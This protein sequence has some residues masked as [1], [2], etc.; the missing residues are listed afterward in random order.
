VLRV[1]HPLALACCVVTVLLIGML[2]AEVA[3]VGGPV[4][5]TAGALM[6]VG[7]WMVGSRAAIAFGAAHVGI[8]VLFVALVNLMSW[9]PRDA[10]GPFL[11][12]G[13]LYAL[14]ASLAAAAM[15]RRDRPRG[16]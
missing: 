1:C 13:T 9:S 12:M 15:Q 14:A 3:V 6:I 7:G 8:C 5:A 4:L 10:Y 2:S 11:A 16:F